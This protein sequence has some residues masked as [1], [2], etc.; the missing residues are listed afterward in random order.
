MEQLLTAAREGRE[1]AFA[2]LAQRYRNYLMLIAREEDARSIRMAFE[3]PAE[4]AR[5]KIPGEWIFVDALP[6]TPMG[7]VRRSELRKTVA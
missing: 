3:V 2:Q 4:L 7:K 6:R 5:Y 1:D